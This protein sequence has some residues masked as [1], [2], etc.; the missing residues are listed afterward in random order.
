[1]G[2]KLGLSQFRVKKLTVPENRTLRKIYLNLRG[3]TCLSNI[4]FKA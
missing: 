1:M 4:I 2:V 3:A